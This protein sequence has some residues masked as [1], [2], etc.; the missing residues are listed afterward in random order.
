MA[1]AAQL[2]K[3]LP[4]FRRNASPAEPQTSH[5][6]AVR[7]HRMTRFLLMGGVLVLAFAGL[8]YNAYLQSF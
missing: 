4:E 1:E 7:K 5:V 2:Q 6:S 8:Y 3:R